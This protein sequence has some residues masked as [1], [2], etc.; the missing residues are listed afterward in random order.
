MAKGSNYESGMEGN[1]MQTQKFS[2][3]GSEGG[4][5]GGEK[6]TRGSS[7]VEPKENFRKPFGG[8]DKAVRGAYENGQQKG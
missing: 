8:M 5:E 1:D 3:E 7:R 4:K 2:A 6:S